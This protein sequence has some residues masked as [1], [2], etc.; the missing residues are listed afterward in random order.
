MKKFVPAVL[1][2]CIAVACLVLAVDQLA[3]PIAPTSV[4]C[5]RLPAG[6]GDHL[7]CPAPGHRFADHV[8]T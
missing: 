2:L 8:R 3:V 4:T 1:G 5:V 6:V 7:G